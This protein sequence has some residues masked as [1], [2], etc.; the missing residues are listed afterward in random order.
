M[1]R[2]MELLER[3]K[4]EQGEGSLTRMGKVPSMEKREINTPV[5]HN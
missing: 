2:A 5:G 1:K 4:N 3:R